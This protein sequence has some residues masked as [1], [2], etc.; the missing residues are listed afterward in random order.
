MN[1]LVF[2]NTVILICRHDEKG[3]LG[4]VLNRAGPLEISEIWG[5]VSKGMPPQGFV[6]SGGP[7]T[8]PLMALHEQEKLAEIRV[9]KRLFLTSKL[10]NLQ[11]LVEYDT[12]RYFLGYAGWP[13]G[14]LED[15]LL[16]GWWWLHSPKKK[17]V[18]YDYNIDLYKSVTANI[19]K[20]KMKLMTGIS[21][22]FF[23]NFEVN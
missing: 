4:L 22:E 20:K 13:A 16:Q 2:R 14:K 10:Q 17:F 3:A 23:T 19:S 6:H 15:E 5:E 21:D 18:F 9:G 7:I 12:V 11:Q 8:G 1:D